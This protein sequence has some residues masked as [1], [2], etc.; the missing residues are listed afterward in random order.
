MTYY[1][2]MKYTER[3]VVFSFFMLEHSHVSLVVGAT[4]SPR[5]HFL[6]VANRLVKYL[7]SLPTAG[8][9]AAHVEERGGSSV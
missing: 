9:S 3:V 5:K 7:L 8:F 6:G 4:H 1:E 2:R